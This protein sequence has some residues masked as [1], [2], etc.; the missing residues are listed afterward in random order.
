MPSKLSYIL[1]DIASTPLTPPAVLLQASYYCAALV[2]MPSV[3]WLHRL[4][5]LLEQCQERVGLSHLPPTVDCLIKVID[6]QN[7][8]LLLDKAT[9]S[10]LQTIQLCMLRSW[11]SRMRSQIEI[12]DTQPILSKRPATADQV[13]T[14]NSFQF[15]L[16]MVQQPARQ[17]GENVRHATS[18][19]TN[20]RVHRALST[21][22]S[23]QQ[24]DSLLRAPSLSHLDPR[25]PEISGELESFFDDLA[26]LDNTAVSNSQPQFMQNLGFAPNA[27]MADLFNEYIPIQS[28]AFLASDDAGAVAFDQYSFY[29]AG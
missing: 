21:M 7:L 26:S 13:A 1:S 18:S 25:Y 28:S 17:I 9:Q 22:S 3:L 10:R 16:S 12:H 24:F 11:P 4:L 6:R 19:P 15:P 20:V 5:E 29:G 27:S 8:N 14:P 23:D 2:S